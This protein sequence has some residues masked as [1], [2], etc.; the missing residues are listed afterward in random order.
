MK[1]EKPATSRVIDDGRRRHLRRHV[2]R[3][4]A[5]RTLKVALDL[6]TR[7]AR[8]GCL[9]NEIEVLRVRSPRYRHP[10]QAG[11]DGHARV[12]GPTA[13]ARTHREAIAKGTNEQKLFVFGLLNHRAQPRVILGP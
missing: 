3:A 9:P 11:C 1:V 10:E 7:R 2:P 8:F 12:N 6:L 13:A 5:Q 4:E